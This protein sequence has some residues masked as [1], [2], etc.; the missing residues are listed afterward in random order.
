M[1]ISTSRRPPQRPHRASALATLSLLLG[2]TVAAARVSATEASTTGTPAVAGSETTAPHT[3]AHLDPSTAVSLRVEVVGERDQVLEIPGSA[4]RLSSELAHQPTG[5]IHRILRAVPGVSVQEEDGYGLRPNIG[6]RGTGVERSSKITLLEDGVLIAPA[7]YAAPAAYYFPTAARMRAIEVRKGS[8]A[9][10]QGPFS[11]GGA[12]NLVSAAIPSQASGSVALGVGENQTFELHGHYGDSTEQLGYL[13]EIYGIDTSGFKQLDGPRDDTGFRLED[14]LTKVRWNTKAPGA[15][16]NGARGRYH[17]IELKASRTLQAGN[18]TYIGLTLDDFQRQPLR[19]YAASAEDRIDTDHEQ[20]QLRHHVRPSRA[21]DVT[22]T[23]YRN[24]FFR[25][26]YKN[27]RTAGISNGTILADPGRYSTEL[28]YLRGELDTPADTFAL[29]NNRRNYLATGLQSLVA[30]Q[31]QFG[32]SSHQ[33]ELGV[34]AHRDEEDRFQEDD[35]W[36]LRSGAM[37]LTSSGAPGSQS[38]RVSSADALSLFLQDR[39]HTGRF[40]FSPGLRIESIR[41]E[42]LDFSSSDPL[43]QLSPARRANQIDEFVPGL[44]VTYQLGQSWTLFGGVHRGFA[45]P[46]PASRQ[47]VEA[48]TSINYEFGVRSANA[49]GNLDLVGFWS[50]YD[51]LLGTDTGSGGGSGTGEQFNGGAARVHGLEVSYAKTLMLGKARRAS[52]PVRT[53]Y[54]FTDSEF[55]TGFTSQFADWAPSVQHGDAL[56]YLAQHQLFGEVGALSGTW[57]TYLSATFTSAARATAGQGPIPESEKIDAHTVFDL[58][59]HRSIGSRYRASLQLQNLTDEIYVAARR[60]YGL[61]PGLD[62]TLKLTLR[63][64]L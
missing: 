17:Q 43:R 3:G 8:A 42:R 34:R 47:G 23:L 39:I 38:N 58:A 14:F 54:T 10:R 19:R 53:A 50:E 46:S 24:D 31:L 36:A 11:N 18:E 56:P 20:L 57:S 5:D 26:W 28:S 62:R 30:W 16:S 59:V 29:R 13:L 15:A 63:I 41:T 1:K 9:V 6:L 12:L 44:G 55:L 37:V 60:P 48:E 4:H 2:V 27:E 32:A 35:L 21:V 61:R 45:P 7:P 33:I 40:T 51:N 25:N 64:D 22:T 52:L 49:A